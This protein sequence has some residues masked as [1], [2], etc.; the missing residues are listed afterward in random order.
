MVFFANPDFF[1]WFPATGLSSD[2]AASYGGWNWLLATVDGRAFFVDRLMHLVLPVTCIA[3]PGIAYIAEQTRASMTDSLRAPWIEAA[4]ARGLSERRVVFGHALRHASVPI[5]VL[6][7]L[8]LPTAFSGSVFLERVFSIEGV[9]WTFVQ[10]VSERD[11]PVVAAIA[12]VV[13]ALTLLG[14]VV[15]D[16]S[17]AALDP[18]VSFR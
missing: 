5:V 1:A 13:A 4:R 8:A 12:T 2:D 7:G 11:M 18:R 3:Y 16:L 10:A 14:L 17:R 15:A 6:F 9:G